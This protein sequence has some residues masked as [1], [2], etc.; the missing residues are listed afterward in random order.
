MP[1]DK[2]EWRVSYQALPL[3]I[4]ERLKAQLRRL[5]LANGIA[6]EYFDGDSKFTQ[7]VGPKVATY[8][9]LVV[10]MERASDEDMRV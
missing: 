9:C 6:A 7:A 5:A 4:H 10:W 3:N 8:E 2:D 1:E